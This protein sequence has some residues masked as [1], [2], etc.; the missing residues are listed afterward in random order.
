MVKNPAECAQDTFKDAVKV[1]NAESLLH[2]TMR[3]LS[4]MMKQQMLSVKL[5]ANSVMCTG[6][7]SESLSGVTQ[8]HERQL[9]MLTEG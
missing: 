8:D 1:Q 7:G 5:G 4:M 6:V 2:S 9:T 3:Q